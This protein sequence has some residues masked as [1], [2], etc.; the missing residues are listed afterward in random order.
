MIRTILIDDEK[1]SLSVLSILLTEHCPQVE[2]ISL[3]AAPETGYNAII[4]LEPLKCQESMD[5]NC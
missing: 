2:I 1:D 4:E 3:C 5:L